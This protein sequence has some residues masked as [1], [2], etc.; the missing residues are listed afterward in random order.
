MLG[1]E[2]FLNPRAIWRNLAY[3]SWKYQEKCLRP[4]KLYI[5]RKRFPKHCQ[6]SLKISDENGKFQNLFI[7][8]NFLSLFQVLDHH[9]KRGGV[10]M[11]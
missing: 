2:V 9:L 5:W 1:T 8:C 4:T 10:T 3:T 6:M 7:Y 11:I